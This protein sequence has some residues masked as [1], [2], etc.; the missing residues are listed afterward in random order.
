MSQLS[1]ESEG[2]LVYSEFD[3][4]QG[5]LARLLWEETF[6]EYKDIEPGDVRLLYTGIGEAPYL[7]SPQTI[8]IFGDT[9]KVISY[10]DLKDYFGQVPRMLF[11]IGS[12]LLADD[13]VN[14][15]SLARHYKEQ[16]VEK[17]V[18]VMT[19]L[20]HERQ[21]HTFTGPDGKPIFEA[22]TLKEIVS[23]LAAKE[24]IEV[25]SGNGET[26]YRKDRSIDAGFILQPHSFRSVEF[27]LRHKFPLLPLDALDFLIEKAQLRKVK[28]P[29]V[30]SADKG[31]KDEARRVA[32]FL[33]CLRASANKERDRPGEGYPTVTL[34]ENV[35]N[36][37]I[38]NS[39]TVIC[40]EDEIREGGTLGELGKLGKLGFNIIVLAPKAIIA[41]RNEISAV[42]HLLEASIIQ[43]HTTD[44]VKPQTETTPINH[45]LSVYPIGPELEKIIEYL[46]FHLVDPDNPNWFQPEET[47]SLVRLELTKEVYT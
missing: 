33:N 24:L 11:L 22:T 42:D 21:D 4:S 2:S 34:P 39:Y 13:I 38:E 7:S 23:N 32:E 26:I 44:A 6:A 45:K 43:I 40:A 15:K 12:P 14:L 19:C 46:R 9:S 29:Y 8:R 28:N 18:A 47:G 25:P 17:V 27:G 30:V 3:T 5:R 20:A 1:P 16:G 35:L 37:I 36:E 41:T 10:L 31:R